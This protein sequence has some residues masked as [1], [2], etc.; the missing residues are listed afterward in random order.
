MTVCFYDVG[1]H[2]SGFVGFRVT[3]G[4]ESNNRVRQKYFSLSEYSYEEAE[5]L[6]LNLEAEWTELAQQ[7]RDSRR[8]STK[9]LIQDGVLSS[10]FDLLSCV[11]GIA[12]EA[13]IRSTHQ[14]TVF[15]KCASQEGSCLYD[16]FGFSPDSKEYKRQY[17]AVR[18]LMRGSSRSEQEGIG[19]LEWGE[20][21]FGKERAIVMT[22]K[23]YRLF[24]DIKD[25]IESKA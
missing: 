13:G 24:T 3:R 9:D 19:V 23:G 2:G 11:S 16:L 25:M 18:A 17:T 1:E 8:A 7:Y 15:L 12:N 5:E 21:L 10:T 14:L 6:A 22:N 20:P 4:V